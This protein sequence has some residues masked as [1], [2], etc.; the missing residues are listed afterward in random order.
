MKQWYRTLPAKITCFILCVISLAVIAASII[1]A[2]LFVEFGFYT[3]PEKQMRESLLY[4]MVYSDMFDL[5]YTK[6]SERMGVLES[7]YDP[8]PDNYSPE[9]TNLR[10]RIFSPEGEVLETNVGE[11]DVKWD[12]SIPFFVRIDKEGDIHIELVEIG[13]RYGNEKVYSVK[14]YLEEGLPVN[15]EYAMMIGLIGT[16]YDLI[17]WIY[18]IG[19]A[20]LILFVVCFAMLICS[21]ARRAG[22]NELYPGA[23][24]RLPIDLLIAALVFAFILGLELILYVWY[25]GEL[26]MN[27]LVGVWV[28]LAVCVTLGLIMSIAARIKQRTLFTNTLIWRVCKLSWFILKRVGKGIIYIGRSLLMLIRSIPMLWRTLLVIFTAVVLDYIML[29][30]VYEWEWG[31]AVFICVVTNLV[32]LA[33]SLYAAWFMRKLQKG[34]EAIAKGELSYKVDT[35]GMYWDFK[36]HGENLNSIS[37][38]MSSAVEERLKSERM[39]TELITNVSHDIKT[40]LTSII[41]YATL[42]SE[43]SD[44]QKHGEYAEVLVRKSEHLKRLLDDLVEVSKA[45][46]GNLDVTLEPCEAGVLLSQVSGE[47]EERCRAVGLTLVTIC[48]EEH[49][50]IMAD[51]RR[52]WR[53]FENLMHNACKYSL[54]GSRVYLSLEADGDEAVFIFRNTSAVALNISPDELMERFVRGD[55]ARTTEGSGL[56][57][58]IAHS[59]T[60]L[61]GGKMEIAID[62]D[63]FKVTLRFPLL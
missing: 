31:V 49:I 52:I 51:S 55:A 45:N 46:T 11:A 17:Y 20:A 38:G 14:L 2:A 7:Y 62:G 3:C 23:L 53:V 56:G 39:K 48:P 35:K 5:T 58:S 25:T 32:F 22:S 15:D 44:P 1:G 6:I 21:S 27:V 8:T 61:Q 42:I 19:I 18:P 43:E 29:Y 9:N 28:V 16:A 40:P 41:N 34:G 54:S 4:D 36:R 59:L 63:L 60:E 57:L 37:K 50:G 30:M 24:N 33:A 13:Q 47:F 10:Y 12:Y 26:V